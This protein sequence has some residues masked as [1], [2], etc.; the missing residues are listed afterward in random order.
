MLFRSAVREGQRPQRGT[1]GFAPGQSSASVRSL[2]ALLSRDELLAS[3]PRLAAGLE[4]TKDPSGVRVERH[5]H[6][7]VQLTGKPAD[8]VQACDG[9][10]RA[11]ELTESGDTELVK[12]VEYLVEAGVL[13]L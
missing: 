11:R 2:N 4:L 1:G 3:R 7:V 8:I 5:Q 9:R 13:L 10:T 12:V 6:H